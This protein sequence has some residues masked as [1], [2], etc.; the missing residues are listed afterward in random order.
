M[1]LWF[2]LVLISVFSVAVAEISQKVSMTRKLNI[3]SVT[4]NFYVWSMMSLAGLFLSL[5][6]GNLTFITKPLDIIRLLIL[7]VVYFFGGTLYYTSY[8]GN[9]PSIS[10]ILASISVIVST[11]LG[12]LLF[13]EG[14]STIKFAGI[15]LILISI[16]FLNINNNEKFN[17][18][19]LLALLGGIC[20]GLAYTI[21]K[22]F[23]LNLHPFSY[24]I[25]MSLSVAIVSFISKPK[26]IILE[27]KKMSANDFI[28]ITVSFAFFTIFDVSNFFAYK[29]GASVGVVDAMNSVAIFLV[30]LAEIV[31]LKDKTNIKKK[32]LCAIIALSGVICFSFLK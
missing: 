12:I 32:L 29:N 7:G 2:I 30:I 19:N 17:K 15:L 28:P 13:D 27:S 6:S 4:N 20:Y 8:K 18:Y 1:P 9:S 22:S 31:I 14:L 25:W 26:L 11:V 3:S 23:A 21:D 16:V 5:L 10:Q 24:L